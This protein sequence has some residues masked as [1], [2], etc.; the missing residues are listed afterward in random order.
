MKKTKLLLFAVLTLF[1][2]RTSLAQAREDQKDLVFAQKSGRM[3]SAVGWIKNEKTGRWISH[4]NFIGEDAGLLGLND[5]PDFIWVQ[6]GSFSHL[7]NKYFVWYY[8]CHS[9]YFTYPALSQGWVPYNTIDFVVMDMPQYSKIYK[10]IQSEGKA[11][12]SVSLSGF[13]KPTTTEG[14]ILTEITR[15]LLKNP[16]CY[17]VSTKPY[18]FDSV[19]VDCQTIAGKKIVRFDPTGKARTNLTGRGGYFETDLNSFKTIL[20]PLSPAEIAY[21]DS[22]L[23]VPDPAIAENAARAKRKAEEDEYERNREENKKAAA[24]YYRLDSIKN[25][26]AKIGDWKTSDTLYASSA[27]L[28]GSP[29]ENKWVW[30]VVNSFNYE[31]KKAYLLCEERITKENAKVLNGILFEADDYAKLKAALNQKDGKD[32]NII[33]HRL[34]TYHYDVDLKLAVVERL[35]APPSP[36]AEYCLA[37]NASKKKVQYTLPESVCYED[38]DFKNKDSKGFYENDISSFSKL[39]SLP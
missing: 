1:T 7:G 31:G 37:M 13:D 22:L 9:G 25:Q 4:Q 29:D 20:L 6:M 34:V 39:I 17:K 28:T 16:D 30:A 33:S 24:E 8:Y 32:F 36:I 2:I 21:C 23:Y 15:E 38:H 12:V 19:F 5:I 18:L 26:I 14:P 35:A 10:A 11:I 27:I 3:T